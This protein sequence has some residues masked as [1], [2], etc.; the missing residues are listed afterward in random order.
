MPSTWC[1]SAP[2]RRRF[3][4]RCRWPASSR[5]V[6]P[7]P[8]AGRAARAAATRASTSSPSA[9]RRC[10]RAPRAWCCGSGPTAWAGR[11]CGYW[12]RAASVITMPTW[13]ATATSMPACGWRRA[14]CSATSAPAATPPAR[15]R[16]CI[17]ASTAPAARSIPI[18][19][20]G[21][22]GAQYG[23][24]QAA[25]W[26]EVSWVGSSTI[27]PASTAAPS[28][29]RWLKGANQVA[30]NDGIVATITNTK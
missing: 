5:A 12:G 30:T 3:R 6:W 20:C 21:A 2:C 1:A 8:G 22:H 19:S 16:T 29:S 24:R 23:R 7:I 13:S 10:C 28:S 18:R 25:R 9:A 4:C 27:R 14:R 17:T 15:R 11:W 26:V